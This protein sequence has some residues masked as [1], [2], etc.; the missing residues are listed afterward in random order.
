MEPIDP[1]K[2][3]MNEVPYISRYYTKP[4]VKINEEV[5]IDFYI[6][7]YSQKEYYND[8]YSERFTVT[9]KVDGKEDIVLT[10]LKA[11][12]NSISL[13]SF[14][15]EGEVGFSLLCTDQYGRN[16]HELFHYFNVIDKKVVNKYI[17]TEDDLVKYNINNN[18]NYGEIKLV[19][20][21]LT[22]QT[23]ETALANAAKSATVPSKSYIVF[24]GDSNNDGVRDSSWKQSVIKYSEDYDFE[25]VKAESKATREGLQNLL[26]DV[27]SQ[28]YNYIELLPGVYRIDHE[29]T[30]YIPNEFTLDMNGATIKLNQFTGDRAMM[31]DINNVTDSHV[32][33]GNVVG[34][35]YEHDYTNSPNNSEWVSGV[36]ISNGSKYCS[37]EN[38]NI[39]DITGYGTSNGID[40]DNGGYL[41][42]IVGGVPGFELGDIDRTTGNPIKSENRSTSNYVDLSK[43]AGYDYLQVSRYLGYQGVAG[44]T[45]NIICHFYDSNKDYIKSIDSYQYRVVKIPEN[46]KFMKVTLLNSTC[47][48]DLSVQYFRIPTNCAFKNIKIDNARCVGVAPAAMSNM[49]FEN[50]EITRSGQSSAKC[51]F[52]AEDGWD[53]MQ[54]C[55]FRNMDFHNNPNN[56]FLSCAGH[57]FVIENMKAGKIHLWPRINSVVIRNNNNITSLNAGYDGITRSGYPRLENNIVKG[58]I[59]YD[60]GFI[61][62][63]ALNTVSAAV[64]KN[65][66]MNAIPVS[67]SHLIKCTFNLDDFSSYLGSE[68]ILDDCIIQPKNGVESY[69]LSF[70]KYDI[71]REFNN[72]KFLGNV[73]LKN[74][75]QFNTAIFNNCEFENMNLCPGVSENL[76]NIEFNDCKINSDANNF[77]YL[78]PFAYSSGLT[79]VNFNNCEITHNGNGSLIYL[80]AK[81]TGGQM[82]FNNCIINKDSNYILDGNGSLTQYNNYDNIHMDLIFDNTEIK[83]PVIVDKYNDPAKFNVVIK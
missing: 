45:W 61:K 59:R 66:S 8:D 10:N 82:A 64:I 77:I 7:D 9:A 35:Y 28:G 46:A 4:E 36:M 72:C 25:A 3:N 15:K 17:M 26:N 69:G 37:Y 70:N 67:N 79:N 49:L 29:D 78:S 33:N 54:D 52:D 75:N 38:I 5:I 21:D 13:G 30:I 2:L 14:N 43:A 41:H 48:N 71:K 11:G 73:T 58:N 53:M 22:N 27:K 47:P 20:V 44:G 65:C 68:L 63:H 83:I 50:M 57:N 62:N 39:S 19:E 16:S 80:Y 81:P 40:P 31:L 34:D 23:M 74:H 18:G 1:D 55:T 32:I 60:N 76:G 12:D 51:A 24:V 42:Y 6:T 56:E